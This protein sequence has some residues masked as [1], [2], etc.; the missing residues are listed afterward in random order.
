MTP[1]GQI[2]HGRTSPP[3]LSGLVENYTAESPRGA[4][5][6]TALIAAFPV[7]TGETT[8]ATLPAWSLQVTNNL[9]PQSPFSRT[10]ATS[11]L[12]DGPLSPLP[13]REE[14]LGT[15]AQVVSALA[16]SPAAIAAA[17]AT[18][19][20]RAAAEKAKTAALVGIA[21]RIQTSLGWQI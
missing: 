7:D 12:A 1:P 8:A 18:L 17:A 2:R 3:L 15:E 14:W 19:V 11:P 13:T 20:A 10:R 9:Y 4:L 5:T 21:V 16:G 6:P